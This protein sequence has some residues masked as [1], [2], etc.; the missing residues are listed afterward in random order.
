MRIKHGNKGYTLIELLVV[1]AILS[2]LG[3]VAVT[4]YIGSTLKAAR[5]EAYS[6]L[7]TLRMFQEQR[8]AERGT[9]TGT[10]ADFP[11]FTPGAT[12]QYDYALSTGDA[13]PP[14]PVAAPYDGVPVAQADC[15]VATADG[16]DG[17]KVADDVFAIDCNNN[18]NF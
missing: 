12:A 5:T 16:R 6:N 17:S 14:P 4:S 2:I 18:K 7:E 11:G 15:F 1:M 13:L 3:T 8:F 9:Y 10:L